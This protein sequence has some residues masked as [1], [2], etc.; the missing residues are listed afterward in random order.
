MKPPDVALYITDHIRLSGIMPGSQVYI[1]N[2]GGEVVFDGFVHDASD[3][4][5]HADTGQGPLL[6]R[7]YQAGFVPIEAYIENFTGRVQTVPSL[8]EDG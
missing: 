8:M 3:L 1:E 6:V 2:A 5:L 7:V 4:R